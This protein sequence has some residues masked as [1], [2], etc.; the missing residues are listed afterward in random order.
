[1]TEATDFIAE[2]ELIATLLKRGDLFDEI[3]ADLSADMFHSAGYKAAYQAMKIVRD[4]GLVLDQITVGD[5][6]DRLGQLQM[7][8][9]EGFQGRLALNKIRDLGNPK[10]AASYADLVRDHWAKREI[11]K[12]ATQLVGQSRAGRRAQDI[13]SDARTL[14]DGLDLVSGKASSRT[15]T[16]KQMASAIYDHAESA[17]RGMIK[18]CPSGYP[19]LDR[20]VTML[21]GDLILIAGRPGQGKSSLLHSIA[22][23]ASRRERKKVGIF[24]LEMSMKQVVS[25]LACQIAEIPSDKILR[26]RMSP[27]E[28]DR[29]ND[30]IGVIE[31]LPMSINDQSG[32]T[33]PQMR[34]EARRMTRDMGGLD[35]IVLDYTQLMHATRKFKNRNE[36]IGEITKGLKEIGRELDVPILAAAQMSRAV[37][38]RSDK[39]PVLS[40]LRE[41]GDLENDSDVV[42]FIYSPSE[43]ETDMARELIIAKHRNGPVGLV[44]L[45]F[46]KELAKFE[47][48]TAR[49]ENFKGGHHE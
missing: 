35:L 7:I 16:P 3:S 28:W 37:E 31:K 26:G 38:Q 48:A 47:S 5:Q 24:S 49:V 45:V 33:I 40:D 43:V 29:F 27:D 30:A 25:R 6:M 22:L 36:E 44:N 32:L 10:A 18:G 20:I 21:A 23:Q 15:Y 19:N 41:S 9:E 8:Q 46:R 11:D 39:R 14:F 4:N 42:M 2:K 17:A 12:I 34:A 13:L 1:M